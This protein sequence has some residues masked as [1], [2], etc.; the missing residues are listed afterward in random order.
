MTMQ[1]FVRRTDSGE[2][3][4]HEFF[5]LAS[6][7]P[8]AVLGG[9]IHFLAVGA[10][11]ARD[12]FAFEGL[13]F[14]LLPAQSLSQMEIGYV[15]TFADRLEAFKAAYLHK[16]VDQRVESLQE[17][18][19]KL[20]SLRAPQFI[21]NELIPRMR[22]L[23]GETS[24]VA[25]LPA[26]EAPSA[27]LAAPAPTIDLLGTVVGAYSMI[28]DDRV[29]DLS[30]VS[31]RLR[32]DLIVHFGDE[33]Y[34]LSCRSRL[35]KTVEIKYQTAL[36]H[37]LQE[38]AIAEIPE[39]MQALR[40]L[41]VETRNLEAGLATGVL[42]TDHKLYRGREY[43]ILRAGEAWYACI[44]VPRYVVEDGGGAL[45]RFDATRVGVLIPTN[46]ADAIGGGKAVVLT[47]YEHM[48]VSS[49]SPYASICMVKP[50]SYFEALRRLSPADAICTYLLD[51]RRT[52]TSGHHAGNG[53]TPHHSIDSYSDRIVSR[54]D[55]E[56][57]GLPIFPYRRG[58]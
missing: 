27:P 14:A 19:R 36:K 29:F 1:Q 56:R 32:S 9:V 49:V 41:E 13:R 5:T 48:F 51:A 55:A 18:R 26:P 6:E 39:R 53:S 52:L 24:I 15:A 16:T 31:P 11:D 3:P 45:Y 4:G 23:E 10:P 34:G 28:L 43:S 2:L 7:T 57:E 22:L 46:P 33:H 25:L 44:E 40:R 8:L 17:L 12:W 42:S 21:V 35:V 30:A 50:V 38:Q 47:A 20:D 54:A 37:A 58:L